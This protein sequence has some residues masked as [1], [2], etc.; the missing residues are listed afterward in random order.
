MTVIS[1][2]G[3][4]LVLTVEGKLEIWRGGEMTEGWRMPDLPEFGFFNHWH[5]WIDQCLGIEGEVWTPFSQ[6]VRIT[7]PALLA[8]KASRFPGKELHWDRDSLTFTN[9]QEATDTVIRRTY[10][11]GFGPPAVG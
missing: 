5:A 1:C 2:E 3:G 11:D 4:T 9:H 10:R 8:V 7:E 6:A